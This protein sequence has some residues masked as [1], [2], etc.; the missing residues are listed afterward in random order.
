MLAIPRDK[1]GWVR[2]ALAEAGK[3]LKDVAKAWGITPGPVTK[4]IQ[5]GAPLLTID[6][7]TKLAA[8]LDMTREELLIRLEGGAPPPRTGRIAAAVAKREHGRPQEPAP[9]AAAS[10]AGGIIG[11][12][13]LME[14]AAARAQAM[15][16]AGLKVVFSIEKE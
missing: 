3:S 16:P 10:G 13:H 9:A 5:T 7:A 2:T 15:L 1:Y 6:R 14:E 8:M 11:A 12:A 4:W